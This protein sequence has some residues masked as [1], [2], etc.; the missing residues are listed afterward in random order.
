M[1]N[2]NRILI[3]KFEWYVQSP[4]KSRLR[5]KDNILIGFNEMGMASLKWVKMAQ[6]RRFS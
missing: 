5:L 6:D 2:G 1:R 3:G 4:Q